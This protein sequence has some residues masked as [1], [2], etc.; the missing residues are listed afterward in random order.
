MSDVLAV[1]PVL[2]AEWAEPMLES[3]IAP[4]SSLGLAPEDVLVVDNTRAGDAYRGCGL[5][6]YRDPDGHNLGVARSWN[7]AAQRVLNE[8]RR[9]LL[10]MSSSLLFGP[11]MHT[12]WLEQMQRFWGERVI[13][14]DGHSWHL[15]AFHREVLERVGL[16]DSNFYPAYHEATDYGYRMRMVDW[17]GG[18]RHCWVNVLSRATA[19]HVDDVACPAEPLLSYYRAK[20]GGDKGHELYTKPFGCHPL[21]FF[22]DKSIPELA[23]SYGLGEKGV[24]WW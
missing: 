11:I 20:W 6:Y 23:V 4:D 10:L 8:G 9:Y 7:I 17:E 1:V 3:V 19:R 2:S 21:A 12:T 5:G 24:H 13:E 15:I 16:F 18:W 22:Q 14:C